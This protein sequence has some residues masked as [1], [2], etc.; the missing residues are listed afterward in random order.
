MSFLVRSPF[1]FKSAGIGNKGKRQ[2]SLKYAVEDE[3]SI[4][5]L[6]CQHKSILTIAYMKKKTL[7]IF[8]QV[9]NNLVIVVYLHC[10]NSSK[11]P[12]LLLKV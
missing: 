12:Q 1:K 2:S 8:V 3:Y 6:E 9:F 5:E 10:N 7:F 11:R 4:T